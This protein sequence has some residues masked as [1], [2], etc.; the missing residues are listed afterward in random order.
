MRPRPLTRGP[1]EQTSVL[2]PLTNSLYVGGELTNTGT[3]LVDVGTGFLVEKVSYP[4]P[5]PA[6]LPRL[7][8]P[9]RP[10][11]RL[12]RRR[13]YLSPLQKLKSAELFYSGKVQGLAANLKELEAIVSQKQ[14]NL[15]AVEEGTVQG[16]VDPLPRLLPMELTRAQSCGKKSW[17][18]KRLRLRAQSCGTKSWPL[19]RPRLRRPLYHSA[20]TAMVGKKRGGGRV[21]SVILLKLL[22]S[23]HTDPPQRYCFWPDA[24]PKST[25]STADW[26]ARTCSINSMNRLSQAPPPGQTASKPLPQFFR[27]SSGLIVLTAS[28]QP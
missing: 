3:V 20:F 22:A 28:S 17:P 19:E 24:G 23:R 11:L 5:P 16:P 10:M 6:V 9:T 21:N 14:A 27:R 7:R 2:V 13:A 18:L 26:M 15:R 12:R 1:P 4:P 8:A 25:S